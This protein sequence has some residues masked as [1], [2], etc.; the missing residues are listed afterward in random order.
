MQ[1]I[2]WIIVAI[3]LFIVLYVG[4]KTQKYVKG[5]SD[6]LTAGRVAGRYVICVAG[7]EAAMGL[8]SLAAMFENYYKSGFAYSFWSRLATPIGIVMALTGYCI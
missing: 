4:I 8:V 1:L 5:V 6:F 2:D 7:G 3:P